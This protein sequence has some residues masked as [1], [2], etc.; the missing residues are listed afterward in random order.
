VL[1]QKQAEPA[2]ALLP[3][4]LSGYAFLFTV[5]TNLDRAKEMRAAW[6]ANFADGAAS[7]PPAQLPQAC[8][9]GAAG[10]HS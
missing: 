8:P 6:V 3:Q 2:A 4:W 1:L 7:L 5:D 9:P 10:A